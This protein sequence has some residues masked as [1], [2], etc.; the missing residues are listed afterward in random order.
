[1]GDGKRFCCS[2]PDCNKSFAKKG[3]LHRHELIHSGARP[4]VCEECG[5]SFIQRGA[6]KTHERVHTGEKPYE[7]PYRGCRKRFSD[8]SQFSR[9][10]KTHGAD[11]EMIEEL[12]DEDDYNPHPYRRAS[13]MRIQSPEDGNSVGMA[14]IGRDSTIQYAIMPGINGDHALNSR[15]VLLDSDGHPMGAHL[16]GVGGSATPTA[17]KSQEQRRKSSSSGRRSWSSNTIE[18]SSDS[19]PES[20][21]PRRYSN[22]QSH[23]YSRGSQQPEA[24]PD[25]PPSFY[26]DDD[27]DS[28]S[29]D[30]KTRRS[31]SQPPTQQH[32]ME[33]RPHVTLPTITNMM[34]IDEALA[35]D[36]GGEDVDA[37]GEFD[38]DAD[39][40]YQ[41]QPYNTD[42]PPKQEERQQVKGEVTVKSEDSSLLPVP[43]NP[44]PQPR[45]SSP[46]QPSPSA[47]RP[48]PYSRQPSPSVRHA[49]PSV[50][51]PSP[52]RR[53]SP[54]VKQLSP[55]VKQPP[56][57]VR[58]QSPS[59]RQPS[60]LRQPSPRHPSP[61]PNSRSTPTPSGKHGHNTRQRGST[62]ASTVPDGAARA[63]STVF[64]AG[65]SYRRGTSVSTDRYGSEY[66]ASI[67]D[68]SPYPADG[69]SEITTMA[70]LTGASCRTPQPELPPLYVPPVSRSTP[71]PGTGIVSGHASS[72]KPHNARSG[73]L[74][75]RRVHREHRRA[76]R[77][78]ERA[79][80]ATTMMLDELGDE[81]DFDDLEEEQLLLAKMR[82]K[83]MYDDI[84]RQIGTL[85][86]AAK[87]LYSRGRQ[88]LSKKEVYKLQTYEPDKIC[89]NLLHNFNNVDSD[90]WPF[91]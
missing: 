76:Q 16:A 38:D 29:R 54:S 71:T 47:W 26:F 77:E 49:S 12:V 70:S 40:E 67:R 85:A 1:M 86:A 39:G 20:E 6:L 46:R 78:R 32:T 80:F 79:Q 53:S 83:L 52:A 8:P 41:D 11:E 75:S 65:G 81:M 45:L 60:P 37:D 84:R 7:C 28:H 64:A 88:S 91:K 2:L 69:A 90:L 5:K 27:D 50:R 10:K 22:G 24:N 36:D 58:Q 3:D 23:Q 66:A 51:Q 4:H 31:S 35:G 56:P 61:Q 72:S 87:E 19:S 30:S 74:T 21:Y 17:R 15:P 44:T 57:S 43:G 73:S 13:G 33:L 48:S 34:D 42:K 18:T 9:H 62:P 55:S 25:G 59:V 82:M 63:A 68:N 89:L 14:G